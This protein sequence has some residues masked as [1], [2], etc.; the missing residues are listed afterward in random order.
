MKI[1]GFW[2]SSPHNY[3]YVGI[4]SVYSCY[5]TPEE[6]STHWMACG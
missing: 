2:K 3:C 5:G 4:V 6:E 1:A